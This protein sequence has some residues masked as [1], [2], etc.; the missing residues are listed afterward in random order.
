MAIEI[1]RK[2]LIS[3]DFRPGIEKSYR[4]TQGYICPGS[5]RTVRVRLRDDKG[6]LTIKGPSADGGLSRFEWEKEITVEDALSLFPLCPLKL[7]KTRHIVPFGG[8]VFE[9]DEFH[10]DNEGLIVAEV[11]LSSPDEEFARPDWL[12]QEVT[13]DRRF[14]NS[15]LC[16][17]PYKNW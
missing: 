13:G 16:S 8:H 2:F 11:E 15:Q 12:G 10:G 14:Y 7:D 9:V 3:G 17:N 1:E 5:G 4:I 6:F